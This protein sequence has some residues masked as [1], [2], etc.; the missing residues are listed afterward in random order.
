MVIR[1]NSWKC[2]VLVIGK[3]NRQLEHGNAYGN[4]M[5]TRGNAS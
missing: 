1:D 3:P 4:G 5:V 2:I